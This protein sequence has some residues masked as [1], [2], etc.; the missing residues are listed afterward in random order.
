MT[1]TPAEETPAEK[2]AE[3]P[4]ENADSTALMKK[5]LRDLPE[6]PVF[7]I[8]TSMGTI[9]VKLYKDTPKHRDNFIKLVGSR[10]YDGT[11]FHRVIPGFVIQGGDPF[12]KDS[13]RIEE[14][15]KADRDTTL[16]QN[17]FRSTG[18]SAER[19]PPPAGAIS[20][21]RPRNP[22]VPSSTWSRTP[23]PAHI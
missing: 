3:K 20:P 13:T 9:R 19:S 14:W 12:T 16:T 10:Y 7:D 18:T 2:T 6:E 17:S 23:P 21:T 4:K 11:L 15:G 5:A 8:V 1:F 22:A